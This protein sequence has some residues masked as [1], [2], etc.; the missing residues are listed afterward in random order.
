MI[1]LRGRG[2]DAALIFLFSVHWVLNMRHLGVPE[3]TI[4]GQVFTS[5]CSLEFVN[6]VWVAWNSAVSHGL[7]PIGIRVPRH[8]VALSPDPNWLDRA[9]IVR[10]GETWKQVS[11]SL[12]SPPR[13]SGPFNL[14]SVLS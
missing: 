2:R 6:G 3:Q 14:E 5:F 9:I 12:L 10:E 8:T 13:E 7:G 4:S 11:P 1:F